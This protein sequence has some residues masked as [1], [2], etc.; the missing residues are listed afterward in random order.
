MYLIVF[1]NKAKKELKKIPKIYLEKVSKQIDLLEL[2]PLLGNKM[3]GDF[4][5]NYR[6]KIPPLRIIYYPDYQN[7]IIYI[8]AIDFRGG[9]YK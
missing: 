9:I 4:A 5:N 8:R 7:E 6:I 1:E 2:N 3:F